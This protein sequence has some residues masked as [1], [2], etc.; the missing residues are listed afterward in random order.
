MRKVLTHNERTM[1]EIANLVAERGGFTAPL[2]LPHYRYDRTRVNCRTLEEAKLI[3]RLK[4]SD[5]HVHFKAGANMQR[6]LDEGKPAT[7]EFCRT[8]LKD[9]KNAKLNRR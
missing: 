1:D 3:V 8:I 5:I 2:G 6:W 9:A 4:K 7:K